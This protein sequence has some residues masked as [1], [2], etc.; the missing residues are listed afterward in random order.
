MLDLNDSGLILPI[1]CLRG[2][3]SFQNTENSKD[4]SVDPQKTVE[5]ELLIGKHG[6]RSWEQI[7]PLGV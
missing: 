6:L 7:L 3:N 2:E 5:N 4:F 1:L